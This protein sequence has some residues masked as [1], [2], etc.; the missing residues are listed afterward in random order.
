MKKKWMEI[1]YNFPVKTECK[2]IVGAGVGYTTEEP[3]F[4]L[5]IKIPK[6]VVGTEIYLTPEE[7]NSALKKIE[8]IR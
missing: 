2:D 5:T 7:L 3:M 1:D 6:G 4:F 8:E